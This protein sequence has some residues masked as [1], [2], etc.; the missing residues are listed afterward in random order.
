MESIAQRHWLGLIGAPESDCGGQ[1]AALGK[2]GALAEQNGSP[3]QNDASRS[4]ALVGWRS[5]EIVEYQ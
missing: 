4:I 3:A 1:F 5:G 2:I